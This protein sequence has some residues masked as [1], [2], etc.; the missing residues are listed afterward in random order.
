MEEFYPD[1]R[2]MRKSKHNSDVFIFKDFYHN[3]LTNFP[4][5]HELYFKTIEYN[6]N[7]YE[8]RRCLSLI[9]KEK[10]VQ[11]YELVE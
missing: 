9:K 3:Y 2:I 1:K 11:N 6:E 5:Y 10:R 4:W 8:T 7:N